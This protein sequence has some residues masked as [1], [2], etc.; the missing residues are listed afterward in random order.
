MATVALLLVLV[1]IGP[2]Y[3]TVSTPNSTWWPCTSLSPHQNLQLEQ[4]LG[5][6]HL[7]EVISSLPSRSDMCA[8]IKLIR[9][10][11]LSWDDL[12]MVG[13]ES[14]D[15]RSISYENHTI[16]IP[17][18]VNSPSLWEQPDIGAAVMVTDVGLAN[19]T[20]TL[21]TCHRLLE[22]DWTGVFS[23][24]T[25]VNP[26]DLGPLNERLIAAGL[27][28]VDSATILNVTACPTPNYSP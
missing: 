5:Q 7:V 9:G 14:P 15:K 25:N 18:V 1:V 20:L 10:N 13:Q 4:V 28:N 3:C 24:Y 17:D 26:T 21:T 2:V 19:D 8:G 11:D 23:R 27:Q 12:I 16:I 6:W 22:Y